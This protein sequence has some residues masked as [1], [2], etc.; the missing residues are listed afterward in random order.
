MTMV[1]AGL[2]R[3]RNVVGSMRA[4]LLRP[5]PG[6]D[7]FGLGPFFLV[8]PLGLAYAAAAL[9]KVGVTSTVADLR[10]RPSL[11]RV[12]K[13][14]RPAL[15]A[16]SCLHALEYDRAVEAAREV[17]RLVPEAFVVIGGH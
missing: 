7:R 13:D 9:A 3:V 16:I 11:A 15:V 6:N 12:V 8:E 4:L 2:S 14:A 17:K 10:F 1:I 5:D